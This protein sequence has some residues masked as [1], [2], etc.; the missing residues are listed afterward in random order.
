MDQKNPTK[1]YSSKQEHMIAD[2]L[3]WDVVSGSGARAFHPGDIRSDSFLGECKTYTEVSDTIHCKYAVWDKIAAE[4]RSVFKTPVLFLDNG[5]QKPEHTW[6]V[7]PMSYI[8]SVPNFYEMDRPLPNPS[9]RIL[10]TQVSFKHTAILSIFKSETY[11]DLIAGI[12]FKIGSTDVV[13]VRLETF[14]KIIHSDY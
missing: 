11:K 13:L 9:F 4:A 3:G 10:K 12:S 1:F 5:S 2:Y 14:R 6:C 8:K 7:V